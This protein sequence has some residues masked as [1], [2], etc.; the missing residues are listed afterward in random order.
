MIS[1]ENVKYPGVNCIKLEQDSVKQRA[2]VGRVMNKRVSKKQDYFITDMLLQILKQGP[3]Y[4][5]SCIA[6]KSTVL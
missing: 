4:G 1:G 5:V 6:I 3:H 2:F